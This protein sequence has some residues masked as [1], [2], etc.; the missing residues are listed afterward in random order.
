MF[1]PYRITMSYG[2]TI[3][4]TARKSR[5]L[6]PLA[7]LVIGNITFLVNYRLKNKAV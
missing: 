1:K 7:N 6:A 2:V 5:T 3:R 4:A